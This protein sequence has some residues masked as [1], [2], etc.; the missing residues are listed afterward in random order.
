MKQVIKLLDEQKQLLVAGKDTKLV[1]VKLVVLREMLAIER[2]A[3]EAMRAAA[4]ES[5]KRLQFDNTVVPKS[6][7]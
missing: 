2:S 1:D 7:F 6:P 4:V 5:A 3:A